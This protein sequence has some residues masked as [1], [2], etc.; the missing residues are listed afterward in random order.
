MAGACIKYGDITEIHIGFRWEN[1]KASD[2]LKYIDVDENIILKF[3]WQKENSIYGAG[4]LT[5][6]KE[7]WLAVMNRVVNV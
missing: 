7:K 6:K 4:Y 3:I 1:R 2:N 5:Q